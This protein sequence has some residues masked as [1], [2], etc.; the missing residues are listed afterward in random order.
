MIVKRGE[1]WLAN[2]NPTR[3]S[4]QAEIRPVI[5][6]QHDVVSQWTTTV[7]T[8]PLTTNLRRAALPSCVRIAQGEGGLVSESVALCHQLRV[9]LSSDHPT[10]SNRFSIR[11]TR[12]SNPSNRLCVIAMS[13]VQHGHIAPHSGDMFLDLAYARL[14]VIHRP[15]HTVHDRSQGSQVFQD[16]IFNV[17]RHTGLPVGLPVVVYHLPA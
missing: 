3:G 17:F 15:P 2:L 8:I 12:L 10:N 14:E 5:I 7:L 4:E 6:F 9:K 16:Q 11:S 1:I 13:C